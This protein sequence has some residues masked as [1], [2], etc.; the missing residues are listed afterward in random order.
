M[1]GTPFTIGRWVTFTFWGWLLGVAFIL[2]LSSL[3]GTLGIE[4]MQFY[5]GVGMGAGVGFT[6]WLVLRK[7]IAISKN[8]IWTSC[9]GMGI[10][11]I[12]L[13]LLLSG[14]M[15]YKL[16][17]SIVPGSITAGIL[18]YLILKTHGQKSHLWI[19]SSV[20]G[21]CVA[22]A[23][24]FTIDYTNALKPIISSNLVLAF[25][26][27]V[28]ILAGGVVLGIITGISMKKILG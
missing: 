14:T 23:T 16:P 7:H 15:A 4:D 5:L 22:V 12:I 1:T 18:Q 2:A 11:M 26:N 17:L 9:L 13:D 21:W 19:L 27:L 25:I 10:P 8:W 6:Q 3:L 20:I 24:V 28:L